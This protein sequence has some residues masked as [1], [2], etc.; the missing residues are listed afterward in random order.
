M[1]SMVGI[2][3]A[4]VRLKTSSP[5]P[6]RVGKDLIYKGQA[7][8]TLPKGSD[9]EAAWW[10]NNPRERRHRNLKSSYGKRF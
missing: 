8:W 3:P 10:A 6:E 4:H 9:K 1:E 5:P 7:D 2:G